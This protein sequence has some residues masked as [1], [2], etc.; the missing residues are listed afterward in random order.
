MI[1][2]NN[3]ISFIP[4]SAKDVDPNRVWYYPQT[5]FYFNGQ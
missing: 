5:S 1:L 3:E 4:S 2:S